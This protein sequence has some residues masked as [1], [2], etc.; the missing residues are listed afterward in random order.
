MLLARRADEVKLWSLTL[1]ELRPS[2]TVG[3]FEENHAP[4]GSSVV[5]GKED[6]GR[7][8]DLAEEGI[9]SLPLGSHMHAGFG[10]PWKGRMKR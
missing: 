10:G 2:E 3:K 1:G 4:V 8:D 9:L 5:G 7:P 6:A